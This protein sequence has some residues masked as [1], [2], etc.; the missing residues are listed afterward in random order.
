MIPRFSMICMLPTW[1]TV[2]SW[3]PFEQGRN[4]DA[5]GPSKCTAD[6]YSDRNPD[7]MNWFVVQSL[8]ITA[9]GCRH[10]RLD[11]NCHGL[12]KEDTVQT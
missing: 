7:S 2:C 5:K 11:G 10:N 12:A 4:R 3:D 6:T 8:E 9:C 1:P